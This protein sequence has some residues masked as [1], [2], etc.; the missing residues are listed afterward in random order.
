[1]GIAKE[2]ER[3][4]SCGLL[5]F[6]K[7]RRRNAS[8]V[9]FTSAYRV[10]RVSLL[11]WH[12]IFRF[13]ASFFDRLF[14]SAIVNLSLP[15]AA[16]RIYR[17][18]SSKRPWFRHGIHPP[19]Y[20]DYLNFDPPLDSAISNRTKKGRS[21]CIPSRVAVWR[22]IFSAGVKYRDSRKS[23]IAT[24]TSWNSTRWRNFPFSFSFSSVLFKN[25]MIPAL[26]LPFS[27]LSVILLS[28]WRRQKRA[29]RRVI[30]RFCAS[31]WCTRNVIQLWSGIEGLRLSLMRFYV[32]YGGIS[33]EIKQ[34]ERIVNVK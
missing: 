17:R 1:M 20:R 33:L 11:E 9:L 18:E 31:R 13:R 3:N 22:Y 23:V 6:P 34:T 30:S 29:S 24:V 25:T 16:S 27:T 4:R 19:P 8:I 10:N 12:G 32:R 2:L 28:R 26:E 7:E 14:L 21:I 15:P 5:V